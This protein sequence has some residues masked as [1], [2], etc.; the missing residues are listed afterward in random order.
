[1]R[2]LTRIPA[3]L[4][5]KY[6]LTTV[7]FV[8]WILFFD[9]RDLITTHFREKAQLVKL[10]D[11]RRYYEQQIETTKKELQELKTNPA[12]VERYARE[13]YL[14]KRDNEDLFIIRSVRR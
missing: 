11:S 6:L 14:M 9:S 3:W 13:K 7:G 5:N 1:M 12:L 4:K 8:V 10:E 2:L